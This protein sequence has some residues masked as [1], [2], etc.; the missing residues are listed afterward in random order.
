ME[1]GILAINPANTNPLL[2]GVLRSCKYEAIMVLLGNKITY[3]LYVD[4]QGKDCICAG[5]RCQ[6]E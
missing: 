5:L 1:T 6:L 4:A 2:P 3:A